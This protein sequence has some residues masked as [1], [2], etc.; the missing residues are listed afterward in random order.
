MVVFPGHVSWNIH[1]AFLIDEKKMD[2]L[3]DGLAELFILS[4]QAAECTQENQY[5]IFTTSFQVWNP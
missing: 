4:A 5:Q 1:A 2:H 3:Q